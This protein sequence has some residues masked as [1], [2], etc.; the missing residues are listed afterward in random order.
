MKTL[1]QIINLLD[2]GT[3]F[4]FFI[5]CIILASIGS[6]AFYDSYMLYTN[7]TDTLILKFKPGYDTKTEEKEEQPILD[8]M[9]G[10]ITIDDTTI[11][12][13]IMQG[14]TNDTFLNIDP[15]G[16]YSL[17]GSIFLDYRNKK[18]FSDPYNLIYGHHMEHNAM[19][20]ALDQYLEKDFFETHKKGTLYIN[21]EPHEITFFAVI[22]TS[23][24][25]PAI[26]S[27]TEN[28]YL[29]LPFV[30]ENSLFLDQNNLP[31][32]NTDQLIAL[33]TCKF[34]DNLIRTIVFGKF[35]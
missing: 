8:A 18:N 33:S 29:T 1:K 26:F 9:A 3:D 12:Y 25:E 6:Y 5:T 15:F 35:Q 30:L 27:P 23:A 11:D 7:A 10:W 17:S 19:F 21:N 20:G 13:P 2:K 31:N 34:P 14:E 28:D 24:L 4:I 32:A 16:N 22:E